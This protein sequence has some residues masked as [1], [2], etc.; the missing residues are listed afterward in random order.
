MTTPYFTRRLIKAVDDWQAG[1]VG[2]AKKATAIR[3]ALDASPLNAYFTA[4]DDLCFRRSVLVKAAVST[5][6][7]EF[8]VPEETSSWTTRVTV[9]AKFKGGPPSTPD[10]GVIFA[11]QP[12]AGEV[13]L[14]LER[15]FEH[16]EF[17]R[18]VDQWESAGLNVSRGIRRYW[19]GQH[20]VVMEV[21]RVGHDEI[22]AWGGDS[23]DSAKV[24]ALGLTVIGDTSLGTGEIGAAF[25]NAGVPTR[26]WVS[27][28]GAERIYLNWVDNVTG[29]L[30]GKG[31]VQVG[32]TCATPS[33]SN[34]GAQ[35]TAPNAPSPNAPRGETE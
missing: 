23:S 8:H 28:D 13:V 6:Y 30:L 34:A 15:L 18:S 9:A 20:E 5:L 29:R 21:P 3:N 26:R 12:A 25:S 14:N 31:P 16:P 19:S 24:G 11:H 2:K 33:S 35:G 10:P 17:K 4:C 32:T 7:F 27:G 1:S 22:Y